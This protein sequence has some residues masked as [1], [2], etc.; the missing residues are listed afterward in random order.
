MIY[1]A[2]V[3]QDNHHRFG[4]RVT[5]TA[6]DE[7]FIKLNRNQTNPVTREKTTYH[8]YA[9]SKNGGA[10]V[11]VT[12][13]EEQLLEVFSGFLAMVEETERLVSL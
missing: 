6:H 9:V 11:S 13:T 3:I 2:T 10:S 7:S 8:V 4:P 5:I 1:S 12:L